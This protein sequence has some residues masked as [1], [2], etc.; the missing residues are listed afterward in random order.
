VPIASQNHPFGNSAFPQFGGFRNP[1]V[2]SIL[3]SAIPQSYGFCGSQNF[4]E[5]NSDSSSVRSLSSVM[6]A[7]NSFHEN[8]P[9]K[10][11]FIHFPPFIH[12]FIMI[13]TLL[14]DPCIIPLNFYVSNYLCMS[15]FMCFF[16]NPKCNRTGTKLR[17]GP[18]KQHTSVTS[19]FLHIK[20]VN[21]STFV[22]I[23]CIPVSF[24]F[25]LF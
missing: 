15:S 1:E 12:S 10:H 2:C 16:S 20:L 24:F 3:N 19:D 13:I 7:P 22:R 23:V 18:H 8:A 6:F 11:P 21:L 25:C 9:G 14:V 5:L 17:T 4:Q